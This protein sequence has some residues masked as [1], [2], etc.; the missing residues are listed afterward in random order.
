VEDGSATCIVFARSTRA[1]EGVDSWAVS[2]LKF[3][4]TEHEVVISLG[5]RGRHKTECYCF[6]DG[7]WS[8]NQKSAC[9][10]TVESLNDVNRPPVRLELEQSL[11]E[12]PS[13]W[14][15]DPKNARRIQIWSPNPQIEKKLSG[16][17][18]IYHWFDNDKREWTG[19][20]LLPEKFDPSIRYPLVIQTHGFNPKEFLV[21]GAWATA[22][23]ARPLV[24][25]GF[26][27]LQIEDKNERYEA[28]GEAKIHINGYNAAID[29]LA[30]SGIIDPKRVG[31][32][33]FSRTCWYIEES[34]IE[35]PERFAA[36]V[37]ADGYDSSYIQYMLYRPEDPALQ[38]ER[39]HGGP[40]IGKGLEGWIKSAPGFRL[41]ELRTPLRLQAITPPVLLYE[42]EIYA[43]LR[44]QNK[45]VDMVYFP[46]G[47]HILQNPAERMASEQGDVD[48]FRFWLMGEED[49]DPAKRSQ[50]E[51]WEKMRIGDK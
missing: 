19:G 37:I 51:R 30:E 48:W 10:V 41:S 36:A 1:N 47:Q 43:S 26:V 3:G 35:S 34:M 2:D 22:N 11:N 50:Y 20:L 21:D 16:K 13:L 31:I 25:A 9:E 49:G 38:A 23:A 17:A 14:A 6:E 28:L 32:I 44:A 5:W 4:R 39:D 40:P 12:P 33:G 42:W 27:V 29:Q 7:V 24:S 8:Q 15:A 18:S 45:A 46:I